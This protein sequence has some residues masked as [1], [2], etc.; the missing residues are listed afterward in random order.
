MVKQI[1]DFTIEELEQVSAGDPIS[2]RNYNRLTDTVNRI[3]KGVAPARQVVTQ[4]RSVSVT[5]EGET[6]LN[7]QKSAYPLFGI[8]VTHLWQAIQSEGSI[9]WRSNLD[10]IPGAMVVA[11]L[12][13]RVFD[14]PVNAFEI[15]DV[16]G[17]VD[18]NLTSTPVS[19]AP[20]YWILSPV[21][22]A[23]GFTED[24]YVPLD[25][26][27]LSTTGGKLLSPDESARVFAVNT[28]KYSRLSD[29]PGGFDPE[30]PETWYRYSYHA[31]PPGVV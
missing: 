12:A 7:I 3:T 1:F 31:T 23:R 27:T 24:S 17:K 15:A 30:D 13:E 9:T 6:I 22:P 10:Q 20:G 21:W 14:V 8:R 5:A 29:L 2:A 25:N 28:Y 26:S 19:N 16:P 4:R 18:F 11:I